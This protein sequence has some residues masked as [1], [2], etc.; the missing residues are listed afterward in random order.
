MAETLSPQTLTVVDQVQDLPLPPWWP[1]LL[2][3]RSDP[4]LAA[5]PTSGPSPT[6][7]PTSWL[8]P[9]PPAPSS[10]PSTTHRRRLLRSSRATFAAPEPPSRCTASFGSAVGGVQAVDPIVRGVRPAA[11]GQQIRR[12]EGASSDGSGCGGRSR[13]FSSGLGFGGRWQR[14]QWGQDRDG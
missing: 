3:H 7:T 8:A 6:P 14:P 2:P 1:H 10:P 11:C 9:P 12:R 13:G 5:P 4:N